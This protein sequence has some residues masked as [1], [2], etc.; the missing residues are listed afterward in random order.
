MEEPSVLDFV[1][2][3]LTFWRES[4]LNIPPAKEEPGLEI[5]EE[6]ISRMKNGFWRRY[7]V[8]LPALAHSD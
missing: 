4:T 6:N 5:P 2:E 8:F 1:L 7:L 3:K